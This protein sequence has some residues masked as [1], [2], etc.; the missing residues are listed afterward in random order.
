MGIV[1]LI[2]LLAV[3]VFFFVWSIKGKSN[4]T[5]EKSIVR[6]AE[7]VLLGTLL[8]TGIFQLSSF[9]WYILLAVLV[10]QS[11]I[12]VFILIKKNENP[13]KFGMNIL[14]VIGSGFLYTFA[15]IPAILF[16]Q[17]SP[18]VPTGSCG[19]ET[20][21]YTWVDK[22]RIETY[23]NTGENRSVTADFWYPANA[24]VKY[25]LVIF[26]HGIYGVDTSNVSTYEELASNGYV[27]C[28]ISYT[29]LSMVTKEANGRIIPVD[30]GF[31]KYA[32]NDFY[33]ADSPER[34]YDAF[35]EMQKI[36][37]ADTNFVID[38]II[39]NAGNSTDDVF[40][41]VDVCKIGLIGHSLGSGTVTMIA[42]ERGDIGA[43]VNLDGPLFGEVLGYQNGKALLR[44]DTCPV[45]LLN[46]YSDDL[47]YIVEQDDIL[48]SISSGE[49]DYVYSA[50]AHYLT[51]TPEYIYNIHFSGAKHLS[52]TDLSLASPI[53]ANALQ[54][55]KAKIDEYYCL[56]TMNHSILEFFDYNLKGGEAPHYE[57]EY[58]YAS[59]YPANT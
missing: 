3:E 23:T 22:S 29:Y 13:Y 25:P 53:L 27:V 44:E 11:A 14:R 37:V 48:N 43:V 2:V 35:N 5:Q 28:A 10:I 9:R 56:E 16:P 50:N 57:R 24:D 40:H 20:A 58:N 17:Y 6:I 38:T 21:K 8:L 39:D 34:N 36:R 7:F 54:G 47:W 55:G 30:I 15:L 32:Q 1:I 41:M 42:R 52:L 59:E 12:G 51:D 31:L 45:P 49:R 19:I 26:S 46:V 18:P 33:G 4:H